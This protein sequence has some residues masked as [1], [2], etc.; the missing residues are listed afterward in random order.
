[1]ILRNKGTKACFVELVGIQVPA[2][3]VKF[4]DHEYK[5]T[6]RGV[7][8]NLYDS[9][10][11]GPLK[12]TESERRLVVADPLP[13]TWLDFMREKYKNCGYIVIIDSLNPE[14]KHKF[15]LPND[16]TF[17]K[18]DEWNK[19]KKVNSFKTFLDPQF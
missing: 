3:E 11:D 8:F 15:R 2:D 16:E 5:L 18:K 19:S 13:D 10:N 9:K 12:L 17:S 4:G 6:E 7:I 14:M 1:M